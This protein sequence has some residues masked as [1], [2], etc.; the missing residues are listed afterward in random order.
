M[1]RLGRRAG[2]LDKPADLLPDCFLA[3][4]TPECRGWPRE[5]NSSL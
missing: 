5:P 1:L 2:V 3:R 4:S